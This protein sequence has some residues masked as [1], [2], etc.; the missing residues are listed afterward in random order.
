MLR[1]PVSGRQTMI[2]PSEATRLLQLVS[3]GD[4][5]AE[6]ELLPLLYQEL[7]RLAGRFMDGERADHTLQPTAL[8]HEAYLR[9][10]VGEGPKRW[11]SRA[12]FVRV[13]AH[14]MRNV[15]VD[16]ARARRT[17]KRGGGE[18][19]VP[20]DGV[21]AFF[22]EQQLDLLVLNEALDRL[23]ELD[24]ELGRVVELR[25][26]VGMT[27]EEISEVLGLSVPT[28]ERRWRVARMWLRKE[29]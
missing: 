10:M 27:T 25:F 7:L 12:H 4:Q 15:L 2:D 5:E 6:S 23:L 1:D 3:Q 18:K 13:A 28:V 16:H 26:F 20:L 24:A 17:T 19:P 21:V 29:L 11:E 14:A 9:L 22:E 8:V